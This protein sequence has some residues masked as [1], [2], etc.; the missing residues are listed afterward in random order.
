MPTTITLIN[1]W[2]AEFFDL[3]ICPDEKKDAVALSTNKGAGRPAKCTQIAIPTFIPVKPPLWLED[4]VDGVLASYYEKQM[5]A[6]TIRRK[7]FVNRTQLLYLLSAYDTF[8][9]KTIMRGIHVKE[10]AA[11]KYL[12]VITT[13]KLFAERAMSHQQEETHVTK[14]AT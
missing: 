8:N 12:E 3:N 1:D 7:A 4:I 13:I 2:D 10:R 9:V 6:K 11:R 14:T 5:T